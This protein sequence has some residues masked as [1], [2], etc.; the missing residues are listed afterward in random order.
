MTSGKVVMGLLNIPARKG[1]LKPNG[2]SDLLKSFE[3]SL[4]V[5]ESAIKEAALPWA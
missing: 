3:E 4:D 5:P 1:N 2:T